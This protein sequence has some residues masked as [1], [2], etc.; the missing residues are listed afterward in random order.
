VLKYIFE[1]MKVNKKCTIT[2][3]LYAHIKTVG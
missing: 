2:V 3:M 1:V